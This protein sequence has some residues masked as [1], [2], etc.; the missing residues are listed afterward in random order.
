MILTPHTLTNTLAIESDGGLATTTLTNN[1]LNTITTT[2]FVVLGSSTNGF[3]GN[4]IIG[5]N[6]QVDGGTKSLAFFRAAG[7][8]NNTTIGL[9]GVTTTGDVFISAGPGR[10]VSQG[11]T[12][13]GNHVGLAATLG[14]G[15]NTPTGRVLTD[16]TVL[17]I[18]NIANG[19]FVTE[20][21][22]V[23]LATISRNVGGTPNPFR[24]PAATAATTSSPTGRSASTAA[25]RPTTA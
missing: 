2:D 13:H 25:S 3:V 23:S 12:V 9:H 21:N 14:I 8:A 1:D 22:D 15:A 19:A 24:T 4:T 18:N 11:G 17:A 7:P 20:A 5:Q 10:I 16:A 6:A